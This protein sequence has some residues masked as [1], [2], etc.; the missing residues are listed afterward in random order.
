LKLKNKFA[1]VNSILL[2]IV[3][4][5]ISTVG[6]SSFRASSTQNFET[7]LYDNSLLVGHALDE[8]LMRYFDVLNSVSLFSLRFD[9]YGLLRFPNEIK[10]S[11]LDQQKFLDVDR[12]FIGLKSG[13]T[14]IDSGYIKGFNAKKSNREWFQLI[15]DK[16]DKYAITSPYTN[17]GGKEVVALAVPIISN[18][19]TIATIAL[20]L[21]VSAISTFIAS[22]SDNTNMFIYRKDGFVMAAKN[23]A[24]IGENILEIRP[25]YSVFN[26]KD[27]EKI[28]YNTQSSDTDFFAV[29]KQMTTFPWT[30]VSYEKIDNIEQASDDNLVSTI[31]ISLLSIMLFIIL[32]Y[33]IVG[34]LIYA[35]IGGEPDDISKLVQRVSDGDLSHVLKITGNE[36]GIYRNV[37]TMINNLRDMIEKINYTTAEL[38][39][40][41]NTLSASAMMMNDSSRSQTV[42]LEQTA[43]AMNEMTVTVDEV[44]RNA[45]QASDAA[46]DANE[47]SSVGISVIEGM[48]NNIQTLVLNIEN[49][50]GVIQNL[51]KETASIGSI[52]DV[53]RGIADQTN[54]LALNAAIEA[55]RA[56]DQGRGFAVVADE[57][58]S[59]A[60]RTQQSTEEIQIMISTLQAE[61]KRS[62]ELMIN[63]A[64]DAQITSGKTKEAQSALAAILNSVSIIQDMN[65]QIAT[66]AEQQNHVAAEINQ[67]VVEI[68]DS[69]KQS[70]ADSEQTTVLA[71]ELGNMANTLK[72]VVSLFSL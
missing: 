65:N 36:T 16:G 35:P 69:A 57:V 56:G 32:T 64:N 5:V 70:Y 10:K 46:N 40:S 17:S 26:M 9:N 72:S 15:F 45:L 48:N 67:S 54:L 8:K 53:I 58:R 63:N 43:T 20:E 71:K 7:K 11:L 49:V 33:I 62:V 68:N 18:G 24:D 22:L 44:A 66:A 38:N 29:S 37:L 52:L 1:S 14:F 41:S 50:S 28:Y 27:S 6:Y 4:A 60:S 61:A 39:Q 59:L 25:A 47:N 13:G 12:I 30:V 34:R 55:A 51:E 19:D 42:Q 23:A 3:V 21:K 2:M 31:I